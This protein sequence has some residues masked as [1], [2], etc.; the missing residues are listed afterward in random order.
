[1]PMHP[2]A[3]AASELV[4]IA[5]N[6]SDKN[7]AI[8]EVA[9]MLVA[10][11]AVLPAYADSMLE[12][13]KVA[14]TFLG[15]GVAIPHGLVGDKH[16][17]KKD[18]LAILQIPHGLEWNPGQRTNL[19]V[20]IAAKSDSHINMLKRLT[21]LLANKE[22]LQ[23]LFYTT[24][25]DE[26]ITALSQD[27]QLKNDKA[28]A[29]DLKHKI[30]WQLDYPCGLHARPASLWVEAAKSLGATIRIRHQTEMAETKSLVSLLQLG[31]KNGD[32][33]NISTD[34]QDGPALL[35]RFKDI[36]TKI[37]AKEITEAGLAQQ[38]A[39]KRP[40]RGWQGPDTSLIGV[41]ASPGL[42]IGRI[43]LIEARELNVPDLPRPLE[44]GATILEEAIERCRQQMKDLIDDT[45]H[46]LG[47][48][49]AAIFKA[50]AALLDD[51]EVIAL[52]CQKM[53]EGHGPAFAWQKAVE[54]LAGRLASL[55]NP[56]LAAR[57]ADMKDVGLRVLL[58][59]EPALAGSAR[60]NWPEGRAVLV[61]T[62]LA[63]SD[64]ATLD[65]TKVAALTTALGGP[66]SHTAI[67]ARTLGLPAVVA[68]G[69]NLLAAKNGDLAIV[70]GDSGRVYFNP[71]IE[72]LSSA[73]AYLAE[74]KKKQAA[75]GAGKILA[76]KTLDGHL[77]A[78]GANINRPNQMPLALSQGAEGVGLM[79]TEFLFLE[80]GITPSEDEQY[81]IYRDMLKAAK[82]GPVIVRA[83]DI[84]GDKQVAHLKLP[85]EGNPFLGVR[86]A[87][88]LLRRPDLLEPQL[89]ALYR[90]AK[91]SG[92]LHIMFPIITSNAE[93]IELKKLCE[94]IR[95][96]LGAPKVPLGLMI[97]V[98]SAA[99]MSDILARD[100][101]FFSIG[102]NDLT[103]Y[104]LAIDRQNPELATEAEALHPAVLRLIAQTVKGA[105]TQN[106]FVSVCGSLAGDPFGA[107]ILM[108]LG[109][110]ELSMTPRDIPA[111]KDAIR[112]GKKSDFEI[113]AQK[114]LICQSSEEVKALATAP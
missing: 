25:A 108:G 33:L 111:V 41:A 81:E 70:D 89:K 102:T 24:D 44:E 17:V 19:V 93:F 66:T 87:R 47:A 92:N 20:G 27:A 101:D 63:P 9:Q 114:A 4:K 12:R 28:L 59:I 26:I 10:V 14:N 69:Q 91:E 37:S 1:M 71:G 49:E 109:V 7:A 40:T 58:Q 84:G 5:A 32:E 73:Q 103:Q 57:A 83:L 100:A 35:A 76:A 80:K 90:A 45:T 85:V 53:A 62:D 107:T 6:P 61:A 16:L 82:K 95:F 99:I 23:K 48:D 31:L 98:P 86:G 55:G 21:R 51:S 78:I 56:F 22:L 34:N 104:T 74:L 46:R 42:A 8:K 3:I 96:E 11:G 77:M 29:S 39:G 52:A 110:N 79:R 112:Q 30:K 50:Q 64:T 68:L 88:L 43:L 2:P 54:T 97:E 15:A 106:R 18:C 60:K 36:I 75:E 105:K 38:K 113:L 13:E 67:L 72:D 65:V 94:R